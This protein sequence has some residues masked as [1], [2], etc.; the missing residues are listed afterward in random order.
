MIQDYL[1]RLGFT[2]KESSVY[3]VLAEIGIQPA[4]VVARRAGIDRVTTYKTLK[5]LAERGFVQSYYRGGMQCFGIENFEN[6]ENYLRERS[7]EYGDLLDRFP[8][9]TNVLQSLKETED[10]IPRLQMFEGE[11]GMK[12]LFRDMLGEIGEM[13]IKHI[14]MLSAHTFEDTLSDEALTRIV[15]EFVVDIRKKNI[16]VE[17]FEI[18]G[19][20]VPEQVQRLPF[21]TLPASRIPV[22]RGTTNIF[23]VGNAVYLASYKSAKIGLKIKQAELS[24]I[25]HF[26]FDVLGKEKK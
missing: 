21:R 13:K 18:T 16:S 23:I 9:I 24:Q 3:L 17:L 25:F 4:S 8:T 26:L 2:A 22:A 14:R 7:R 12:G 1:Q 15:R 5:K 6:I 10:M 19:G 20:L 11:A